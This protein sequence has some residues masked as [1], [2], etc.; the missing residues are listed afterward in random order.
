M[1][2]DQPSASG[3]PAQ[4]QENAQEH[5]SERNPEH[6]EESAAAAKGAYAAEAVSPWSE[7]GTSSPSGTTAPRRDWLPVAAG[8]VAAVVIAAALA[9]FAFAL[10]DRLTVRDE[11]ARALEARL[12][13]LDQ[14]VQELAA[15]PVP[16]IDSGALGELTNRLARLEAAIAAPRPPASDPVLTN[17]VA[18]LEGELKKLAESVA[19]LGRR[20]DEAG[21]A[22]REAITR[23]DANAAAV[24]DLTKKFA[25][26]S[27]AVSRGDLDA[28]AARIAA[29]ERGDKSV[30]DRV[31]R[32]AIA[33]SLLNAAVERGA[34]FA[35][36]L[37]SAKVLAADP[38][39]LAP[40]EPFANSGVPSAA[41]LSRQL[42]A[43]APSL[44][45]ATGEAPR[46]SRV[47]DR[48]AANA[49]KLVRIH[50]LQDVRGSD[51]EAIIAR[52]EIKAV[53]SDIPGALAE[54]AQLPA[55][56]RAPAEAWIKQAQARSAAL[57]ASRRL[58]ADALAGL[59]N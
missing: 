14:R 33:A 47:L 23:A 53:Q 4:N 44:R 39:A 13:R 16:A 31:S 22:A 43:L 48:L 24:A 19:V 50:P 56:A 1:T 46:E 12:M 55:P 45:A 6:R 21:A 38:K 7:P 57:D 25:E 32:L 20:N 27:P 58:A 8:I 28:L 34:P 59:A 29:V 41:V 35:A 2:S 40:L 10:L 18:A 52:V 17:R 51:P 42:A 11:A 36:E 37:A 9:A 54:L 3:S 49:E 5:A 30:D 26:Q 15:R